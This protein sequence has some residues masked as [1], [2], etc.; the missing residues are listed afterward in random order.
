[1]K[2]SE[3]ASHVAARASLSK[4]QAD[5]AVDAVFST[6]VDA[7]ASGESVVIP[8]FGTLRRRRVQRGRTQ[9]AHRGEP[10][11]R[12]LEDA[13]IQ[14]RQST[15]RYSALLE[16]QRH[17]V[18]RKERAAA[19][20]YPGAR[21][22]GSSTIGRAAPQLTDARAGA[23]RWP[24]EYFLVWLGK[25]ELYAE[26]SYTTA[27]FF[28]V[29]HDPIAAHRA[30]GAATRTSHSLGCRGCSEDDARAHGRASGKRRAHRD[31]RLWELLAAPPPGPAREE[32]RT[33]GA[34]SAPGEV[35]GAFQA[36]QGASRARG[37][38][39]RCRCR[40]GLPVPHISC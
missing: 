30:L 2:K 12:R 5:S 11:H 20:R 39:P 40:L 4:T 16:R 38:P 15:S 14:G 1:M 32:P 22:L 33:G 8:G 18:V 7:L 21:L 25:E 23:G 26:T 35:R 27:I 9:S 6:I 31:P 37:C 28:L 29:Q 10:Q 19:R 24:R 36:G 34:G 17:R 13:L 3:L